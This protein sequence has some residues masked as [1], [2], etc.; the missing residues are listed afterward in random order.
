M[1]VQGPMCRP[2]MREVLLVRAL[3]GDDRDAEA[4][5]SRG[6]PIVED[7]YLTVA[8]CVDDGAADRA[9]HCLAAITD[10]ADWLVVTSQAAL[11]ALTQLTGRSAVVD[12]LATGQAR[13][14]QVA[15]VG[16][17]TQRVL[18]ELGARD[19]VVPSVSTAAALQGVLATRPAA[20]VIAP[21]GSQAM[22]GLAFGLRELGWQVDEQVVY[23]TATVPD[24]PVSADPLAAG[25]FAAVV[26]RSPT[27]LRAVA[28]FV[29][30][31]PDSTLV[32]CG[33]PTTAAEAERLAIGTV[34]VSPAPTADAVA[35]TV[36]AALAAPQEEE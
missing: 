19:V 13:G 6:I 31:L 1:Q 26:F 4:L 11:R 36:L 8:A 14:L 20:S 35:D 25:S 24:R 29:P 33:G 18:A 9:R 10:T 32:V 22:K 16:S 23:E 21:Q 17:A 5:T 15:T 28:R 27:A 30:R 34:V 7:P 2:R 3:G 12:A